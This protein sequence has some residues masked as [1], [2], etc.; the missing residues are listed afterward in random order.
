VGLT[1]V[2]PNGSEQEKQPENRLADGW[3]R[4]GWPGPGPMNNGIF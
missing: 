3:L 1:G 2:W 4:A